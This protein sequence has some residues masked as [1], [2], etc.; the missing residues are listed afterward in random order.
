MLSRISSAKVNLTVSRDGQRIPVATVSRD[1]VERVV[2][3]TA[4]LAPIYGLDMPKVILAHDQSPN[5]FVTIDKQSNQPIMAV[6]TEMLRLVGDADD[7]AAAV[8]GHELG[9]LKGRH[10]SDG[11]ARQ[12]LVSLIGLIAGF[13]LDMSQAKRG[14]DTQGLGMQI[15]GLGGDLVNA[16]FSRDQ[17]READELGI[18]AM[19]RAGFDPAAVPKLWQ[20]LASRGNGGGG[21]WLD[22]HPSHEERTRAMELAAARLVP[23]AAQ[24]DSRIRHLLAGLGLPAVD[25]SLPR[26]RY[27][28][29][30]LTTAD[31]DGQLG[32]RYRQGLEAARSGKL[33]D[34]MAPLQLA[35]E[36]DGD[37]RA[38]S[39]LGD[40]Y[41]QGKGVLRDETKAIEYWER[42]ASSG[43]GP[44]FFALGEASLRGSVRKRNPQ[45]ALRLFTLAH[46]RGV[47]RAT[48]RLGMLYLGT[49]D[50]IKRD[51]SLARR[52]AQLAV[53]LNDPLGKSLYGALLRDGVGG[54]SDQVEGFSYLKAGADALPNN[55]YANYQYGIA[56]ERGAGAPVDK[57]A[58]V[59][60]YRKAFAAG[61]T[62]AKDRLT[63]LGASE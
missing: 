30:S 41:L 35:A 60:A 16:K 26:S 40:A 59:A 48:A 20:L 56:L 31:K 29:F 28:D 39:L 42:A 33:E 18:N 23:Q 46:E 15:G 17:E 61:A 49:S 44:A 2:R 37:E 10:L 8:V 9:H 6:N 45:E 58:A 14:I 32:S 5:A 24:G 47:A 52:L 1:W 50:G 34:S 51:A 13:A 11:A 3:V 22:S 12:G 43:F 21:V 54:P 7:L 62:I 25:D 4:R 19:V 38:L 55:G 63:A 36:E 57:S 53:E 27:T